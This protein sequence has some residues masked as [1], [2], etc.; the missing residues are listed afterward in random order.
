MDGNYNYNY[1][2]KGACII[3]RVKIDVYARQCIHRPKKTIN[4]LIKKQKIFLFFSGLDL[5]LT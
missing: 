1:A 3:L 5:F 4:W 2:R